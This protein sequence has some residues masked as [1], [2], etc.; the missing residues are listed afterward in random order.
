MSEMLRFLEG[1]KKLLEKDDLREFFKE[2]FLNGEK[3]VPVNKIAS[4]PVLYKYMFEPVYGLNDKIIEQAYA[5]KKV[6][7]YGDKQ[8]LCIVDDANK[9]IILNECVFISDF[10][11]YSKYIKVTEE[12]KELL[13]EFIY[14]DMSVVSDDKA[15]LFK[16]TFIRDNIGEYK[17]LSAV[18]IHNELNKSLYNYIYDN[19][20]KFIKKIKLKDDYEK[21]AVTLSKDFFVGKS[22]YEEEVVMDMYQPQYLKI[23]YDCQNRYKDNV[24][25]LYNYVLNKVAAMDKY[26]EFINNKINNAGDIFSINHYFNVENIYVLKNAKKY[27]DEN[28]NK[29]NQDKI[30]LEMKKLV[31]A[32][33]GD[34]KT[35]TVNGEKRANRIMFNYV[36]GTVIMRDVK[37]CYGSKYYSYNLNKNI[38][39]KYGKKIIFKTNIDKI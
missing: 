3:F 13:R 8:F 33:N 38:E 29:Y 20:E 24:S 31:S 12:E 11:V 4:G 10:S 23:I 39:I 26:I 37:D 5:V 17:I 25:Y 34:M 7:E 30:L 6:D 16:D 15:R 35:L 19:I 22:N 32:T 14:V 28:I 18:N 2:E 36:D 1:K 9:I 21:D 27:L